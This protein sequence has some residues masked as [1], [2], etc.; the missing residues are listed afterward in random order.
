MKAI[1]QFYLPAKNTIRYQG[2]N[3]H[4]GRQMVILNI[5]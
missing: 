1:K 2:N 4:S 3:I 5:M